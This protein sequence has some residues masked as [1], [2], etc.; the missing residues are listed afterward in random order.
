MRIT[1]QILLAAACGLALLL[2]GCTDDADSLGIGAECAETSQCDSEAGQICLTNFKGGYCG[3]A[4]CTKNTGCPSGSECI[5]HNGTNYCFLTCGTK[6]ECNNN[7]TA[8]NEANCSSSE[9]LAE[10]GK[11]SKVCV[12]PG[13]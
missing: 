6:T 4:G 9:V 8:D 7:R 2:V 12:P 10:G 1:R 3:L 13:G 11:G 5:A